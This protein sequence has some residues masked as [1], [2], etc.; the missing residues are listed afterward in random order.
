MM[1]VFI[2]AENYSGYG[3][4]QRPF[5]FVL[6]GRRYEVVEVEDRWYSPKV[7]VVAFDGSRY[8]LRHD[9][10]ADFWSLEALREVVRNADEFA[11]CG[12][13]IGNRIR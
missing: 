10:D 3:A 6:S 12:K 7:R 8:P 9:Q 11:T 2:E 1:A 5:R 13:Y 4:D